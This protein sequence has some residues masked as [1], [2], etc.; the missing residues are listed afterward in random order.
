MTRYRP[1]DLVG[2]A[3]ALFAATGMDGDKPATIA[4]T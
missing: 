3:T 4:E 1:A 2:F